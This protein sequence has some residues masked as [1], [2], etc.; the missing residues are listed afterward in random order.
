[1]SVARILLMAIAL[2][3]AASHCASAKTPSPLTP[4]VGPRGGLSADSSGAL[5][6]GDVIRLRIWREPDLSGDFRVD[7][8]GTVVFPKIGQKQVLGL[9]P[10][11]LRSQLVRSYSVYLRN[12]AIEVTLLRRI[13]IL[14]GVRNPGLYPV[15]PT[16]TMADAFA[17][18]GGITPEGK[19]DQVELVRDNQRTL[20]K[21][22]KE[23]RITDT[24]VRSGDQLYVPTRSWLARNTWVLTAGIGAGVSILLTLLR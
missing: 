5:R 2:P 18:A 19:S 4:A 21:I 6:P 1:M 22:S 3:M 9:Q 15:D 16:M 23:T 11:T 14:G 20:F 12:P 10:D 13:T 7:E 24:P 17:L 8:Q